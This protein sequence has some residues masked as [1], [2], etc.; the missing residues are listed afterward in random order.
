MESEATY[1]IVY[2]SDENYAFIMA[3]SIVSLMEN[4]RSIDKIVFYVLA[5]GISI[6]SQ[7]M[8]ENMVQKYD[9]EICFIDLKDIIGWLKD[10]GINTFGENENYTTYLRLFLINRIPVSTEKILYLDCDTLVLGSLESLFSTDMK[11]AIVA[12]VKDIVPQYYVQGLNVDCSNYINAGVL[13]ISVAKWKDY[14]TEDK[15]IKFISESKRLFWYPDQDIINCVL[16]NKIKIIDLKYD[17]LSENLLWGYE[18]LKNIYEIDY[19][20]YYSA[21]EYELQRKYPVVIHFVPN[22]LERPWQGGKFL[23][24]K[25]LHYFNKTGFDVTRLLKKK[26]L[27]NKR[28]F[29]QW[30]YLH[31]PEKI[32]SQIY[33]IK[34]KK[35]LRER[36]LTYD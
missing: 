36:L 18:S 30:L 9:R 24:D 5:D 2:A 8:L 27:T 3:T 23:T 10:S 26:K 14:G 12:G 19:S 33:G 32:V 11:E 16:R 21:A 25:W 28:K 35:E 4:N 1:N 31:F 17:V 22:I 20:K 34:R 29:I 15:I 7:Q 13:L 6:K